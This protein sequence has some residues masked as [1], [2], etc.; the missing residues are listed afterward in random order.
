M[1][2]MPVRHPTVA[3]LSLGLL[4]LTATLTGC[5]QG[6]PFHTKA[7]YQR[8]LPPADF[9]VVIDENHDTYYARTHIHQ[10]IDTGD[11]MSRTTYTIRRDYNNAVSQEY[12]QEHPLTPQQIQGMWDQVQEQELLKGA[13]TWFNFRTDADMYKV[14]V[15]DLQIRGNGLSK[16]YK[17]TDHWSNSLQGLVLLVEAVRLPIGGGTGVGAPQSTPTTPTTEPGDAEPSAIP[18]A[19]MPPTT[20]TPATAPTDSIG[21]PTAL[22]AT[23]PTTTPSSN[24]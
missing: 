10:V 23:T 2:T 3:L 13:F 16:S 14:N 21:D 24:P 22:P 7:P 11:M 15:R 4:T 9:T 12:T 8:T 19:N 17:Q 6:S 1:I 5:G 18:P 20:T